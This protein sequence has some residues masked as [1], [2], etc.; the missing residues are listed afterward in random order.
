MEQIAVI[1]KPADLDL[2]GMMTGMI[3]RRIAVVEDIELVVGDLETA[4][5]LGKVKV[6]E[7]IA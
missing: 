6:Y 5:V 1:G 3:D 2:I 4:A 7:Q